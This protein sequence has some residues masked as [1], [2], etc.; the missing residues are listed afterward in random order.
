MT[1][2]HLLLD[3]F[4]FF[5]QLFVMFFFYLESALTGDLKIVRL[6]RVV[7]EAKGNKEIFLLVERVTKS[8]YFIIYT[9][10]I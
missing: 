1:L 7:C 9:L 6:D 8:K 5:L 3:H 4:N 2:S 10:L